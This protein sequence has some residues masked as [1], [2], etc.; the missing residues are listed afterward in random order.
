MLGYILDIVIMGVCMVPRLVWY[1]THTPH[2]SQYNSSHLACISGISG[3]PHVQYPHNAWIQ[4]TSL[5]HA[6][7]MDCITDHK[8]LYQTAHLVSPLHY[9][10]F[11]QRCSNNPYFVIQQK[12][13]STLV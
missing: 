5:P 2:I 9:Y 4:P 11:Q 1:S 6:I 8:V 12:V 7:G 13:T 10:I 3:L